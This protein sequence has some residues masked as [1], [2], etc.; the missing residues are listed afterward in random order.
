MRIHLLSSLMLVAC[1]SPSV[2]AG[3]TTRSPAE[4]ATGAAASANADTTYAVHVDCTDGPG[5][6]PGMGMGGPGMKASGGPG[7]GRGGPGMMG[8]GGPGMKASGGPGMAGMGE[9]MDR[10]HQLL[11]AHGTFTRK[12]VQLPDGIESW[13][14]S[15]DPAIAATLPMHVDGMVTRMKEGAVVHG[16]DPLF[17]RVFGAAS[18]IEVTVENVAGG[19]HVIERGNTPL[20]VAAIRAHAEVVSW[21]AARGFAEAHR[22]HDIAP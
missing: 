8:R 4:P 11:G 19:V 2:P 10:I 6:K 3:S 1:S 22:C 21:M 17:R 9:D 5:M 7:M 20:A 13:T 16:F 15:A 18:Q 12:V 14:T